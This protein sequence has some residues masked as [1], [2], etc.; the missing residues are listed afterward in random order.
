MKHPSGIRQSVKKVI[1]CCTLQDYWGAIFKW[2]WTKF[3]SFWKF[4][5]C[6]F[7][8][9]LPKIFSP[10]RL[11]DISLQS[12]M[13][14]TLKSIKTTRAVIWHFWP[15][16]PIYIWFFGSNHQVTTYFDQ[17][18]QHFEF[19]SFFTT[20]SIRTSILANLTP[21]PPPHG[22]PPLTT[23]PT[24]FLDVF[25]TQQAQEWRF[26]AKFWPFLQYFNFEGCTSK[27]PFLG[28]DRP[29]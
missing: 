7:E 2:K 27:T 4:F 1:F 20:T 28:P 21:L 10:N 9:D 16:I 17:K 25:P 6:S 26:L 19:L 24:T 23:H 14:D 11:R 15:M 29:T 13:V 5:E 22:A 8:W 12:W 3:T 18:N